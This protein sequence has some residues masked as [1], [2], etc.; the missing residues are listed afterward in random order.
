[1]ISTEPSFLCL[2]QYASLM[3][4]DK[5]NI[6]SLIVIFVYIDI[7]MMYSKPY[8]TYAFYFL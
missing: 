6:E 8:F 3:E 7:C 4:V 2:Y 1:M 5:F